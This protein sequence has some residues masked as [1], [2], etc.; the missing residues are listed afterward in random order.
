MHA[1]IDI[2][3]QALRESAEKTDKVHGIKRHGYAKPMS[4]LLCGKLIIGCG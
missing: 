2:A 3:E 4:P 1:F